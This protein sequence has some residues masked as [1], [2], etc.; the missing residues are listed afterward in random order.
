MALSHVRMPLGMLQF[1]IVLARTMALT[2]LIWL[3]FQ[4][5]GP[6]VLAFGLIVL[7]WSHRR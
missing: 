4:S 6:G 2:S 7:A 1:A 3:T 5:V